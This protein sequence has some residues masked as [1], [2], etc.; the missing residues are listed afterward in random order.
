[1]LLLPPPL[2]DRD[3]TIV[4]AVERGF[5]YEQIAGQVNL[6]RERVRQIAE[7]CTPY[8]GSSVKTFGHG[9]RPHRMTS[10]RVGIYCHYCHRPMSRPLH[11]LKHCERHYCSTACA[12][13]DSRIIDDVTVNAAID[14]RYAGETW[15]DTAKRLNIRHFQVLQTHIWLY[16]I[17]CDLLKLQLVKE[18]W[19]PAA[20]TGRLTG[21]WN[22]LVNCYGVRPT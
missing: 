19:Y 15:K 4:A 10:G 17:E 18:I 7:R 11:D 13:L 20:S 12:G 14:L 1:M 22:W 9:R 2:S 16:L 21:R 8:C 3:R 6:S 5:F